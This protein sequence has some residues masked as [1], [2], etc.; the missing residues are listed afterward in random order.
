M[1]ESQTDDGSSPNTIK[2]S[3]IEKVEMP[4]HLFTGFI[5]LAPPKKSDW[6]AQVLGN[7]FF[8]PDMGKEPNWFHRKMQELCFGIKWRKK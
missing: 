5:T 2:L 8:T 3:G 4:E 7:I 6:S 1:N